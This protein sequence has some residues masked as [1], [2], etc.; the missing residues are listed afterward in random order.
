[1]YCPYCGV[2]HEDTTTIDIASNPVRSII[3]ISPGWAYKAVSS[4]FGESIG[5][6]R[7]NYQNFFLRASQVLWPNPTKR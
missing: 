2:A 5:P 6:S 3:K 1:M 4:Q 7:G